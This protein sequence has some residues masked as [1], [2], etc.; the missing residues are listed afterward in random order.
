MT[1]VPSKAELE[2]LYQDLTDKEI[3]T[4]FGVGE[5]TVRRWRRVHGIFSRCRGPRTSAPIVFREV[6][7]SA[8]VDAVPLCHS[9]MEV[10]RKVGLCETGYGHSKMRAK[11]Q[12]LGLD[13][14]HFGK[15]RP[16]VLGTAGYK[17]DID[18]LLTPG[19]SRSTVNLK[20]RLLQEGLLQERC[21]S[22]GAPPIW[23]GKP[24]TLHL[25]HIN[26]DSKDHRLE[27]LRLLCPNCHSQTLTYAGRNKR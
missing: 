12:S 27:N 10:C 4:R 15:N 1:T 20:K 17:Q 2:G 22:C 6:P 18:S 9:V 16:R 5:A 24:L 13:T 19:V 23:C 21:V 8:I 3:G 25:D 26:G 11:I 14:T 7:D